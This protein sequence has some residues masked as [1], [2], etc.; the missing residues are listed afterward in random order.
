[1]FILGALAIGLIV[2]ADVPPPDGGSG[3]A[4]DGDWMSPMGA[5]ALRQAEARALALM[6]GPAPAGAVDGGGGD[7]E[8]NDLDNP[9]G[10][11]AET[12]IAVD[13]TGQH[14][15][16]G[17]ND[18][19]GFGLNPVS[20]SGFTYSDDG[21]V[22]FVDGGQLPVTTGTSTIGATI[23]PQ[24]F[25]D[26]ELKYLGACNFVYFSIMVKKFSATGTAQTM[27][28]HRSTDCGHTWT[29][30]FEVTSATNPHGLLS[31]ANARDAALSDGDSSSGVRA[32]AFLKIRL[33]A[34]FYSEGISYGDLDRDGKQDIIAG[35]YWY[36]GPDYTSKVP[37]RLPR[38]TPFDPTGDSDCYSIFV[39]DMNQDGWLDIVSLRL[40][41]GSEALWYENP[42]VGGGYWTEHLA[43]SAVHDESP[44][45]ADIDGDG[46][47][48]GHETAKHPEKPVTCSG[49]DRGHFGPSRGTM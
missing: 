10:G 7:D 20:V 4:L 32:P 37:F 48:V 47:G 29:G 9:A 31:G 3:K 8:G 27:C 18:T 28:V 41:G 5:L 40:P 39:F 19:R 1:V 26:P 21:G 43:F 36:P 11:Q 16:I 25:G 44:S 15:V 24:V 49:G 38:A 14:V 23:L 46:G 22:T 35:P 12:S 6:N 45:F 34:D 17:F 13:S 30:P 2:M 33:S 42:K